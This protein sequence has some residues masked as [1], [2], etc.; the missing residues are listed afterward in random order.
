VGTNLELVLSPVSHGKIIGEVNAV[1]YLSR[2]LEV[3]GKNVNWFE[4]VSVDHS[5]RVDYWLD[6]AHEQLLLRPKRIQVFLQ[7][8]DTQLSSQNFI[9]G[10]I[11]TPADV[12]VF[13]VLHNLKTIL[14]SNVDAWYKKCKSCGWMPQC[15]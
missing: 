14:P 13:S 11:L 12:Y 8:L 5:T 2:M 15:V 6:K 10:K 4:N 9:V 1:R 3:N 7:S